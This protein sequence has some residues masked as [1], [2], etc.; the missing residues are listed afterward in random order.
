MPRTPIPR[1]RSRGVSAP[2]RRARPLGWPAVMLTQN[3]TD[4]PRGYGLAPDPRPMSIRPGPRMDPLRP[5]Q[6]AECIPVTDALT[7]TQTHR[8]NLPPDGPDYLPSRAGRT[9]SQ[10]VADVL[11]MPE[12]KAA[13]SAAGVGNY[14]S[15]GTG[16]EATCS[17]SGGACDLAPRS[18]PVALWDTPWP[19]PCSS[20]AAAAP[21]ATGTATVSGGAVTGISVT[22]GGSGGFRPCRD[23]L[24]PS[25]GHRERHRRP[26]D[27][28]PLRGRRPGGT[29]SSRR[30]RGL[31][32]RA[33][34]TI[35]CR[36][37]RGGTS[38]SSIP[39]PSPPTSRW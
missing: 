12:N 36:S 24:N 26:D 5:G 33:T 28:P 10:I 20:P 34:P 32:S 30:S 39:G 31:R 2:S 14:S 37:T 1:S 23:P 22:S 25:G 11:E 16:A 17:I 8:Y 6:R 15:A 18:P 35:S 19:R 3:G 21:R 9:M 29:A 7:L 13:L 38:A 4:P 27:H